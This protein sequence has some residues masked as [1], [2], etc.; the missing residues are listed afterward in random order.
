MHRTPSYIDLRGALQVHL[1]GEVSYGVTMGF[2]P[3]AFELKDTV[4][5]GG[6][7]GLRI[8]VTGHIEPRHISY[9]GDV[10]LQ[11]LVHRR[12]QI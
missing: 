9:A 3:A 5:L 4:D 8:P 2:L 6:T 12:R 1:S 10:R 11:S 7:A